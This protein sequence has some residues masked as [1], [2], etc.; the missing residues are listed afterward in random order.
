MART[1]KGGA[2]VSISPTSAAVAFD[3]A[4]LDDWDDTELL[5]GRRK[6]K[7]GTFTGRA[8]NLIPLRLHRE[9]T[10][11]RMTRATAILAYSLIDAAKLLRAVIR[12]EEADL[13]ARIKCAE[14]LFDRV[15]GR[16]REAISL[17]VH[18]DLKPWQV[19]AQASIV[20]VVGN[21]AQATEE[22]VEGE[23][24]ADPEPPIPPKPKPR[25]ARGHRPSTRT[26]HWAL[27]FEDAQEIRRLYAAGGVSQND[28]AER[29]NVSQKQ[30]WRIVT[31]NAHKPPAEPP[32][33]AA[34]KANRT[35]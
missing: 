12:D 6:N 13:S 27:T 26:T 31:N 1:K 23:I 16:P 20:R 8:P 24:V 17:D 29:F 22:I 21:E 28:L 5:A 15:L 4:S 14:I 18:T 19:M 10:K 35:K 3:G 33:K 25:S 11:R 9:L 34:R 32:R 2:I 30:V 7:Y